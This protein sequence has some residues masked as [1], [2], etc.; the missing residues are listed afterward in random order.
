MCRWA[1][2]TTTCKLPITR[3]TNAR[4][5]VIIRIR[6]TAYRIR[7]TSITLLSIKYCSC[8]TLA[9][10]SINIKETLY[11]SAANTI[12]FFILI[13]SCTI[14]TTTLSIIPFIAIYAR[15]RILIALITIPISSW[16]AFYALIIWRKES[17]NA[18]TINTIKY[19]VW[20]AIIVLII[21]LTNII[22]FTESLFANTCISS[23]YLILSA[24]L[25]YLT[26]SIRKYS[27]RFWASTI[28]WFSIPQTIWIWTLLRW[29]IRPIW[30]FWSIRS[31]RSVWLIRD[32][33][34]YTRPNWIIISNTSTTTI[35]ISNTI[36][37]TLL[38][39]TIHVKESDST[40]ALAINQYLIII[41][42]DNTIT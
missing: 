40:F 10:F 4:I 31:A 34:C 42:F 24:I 28:I 33:T 17:I 19:W 25:M 6:I 22:Y 41:T 14:I 16:W 39:S 35:T 18:L 1:C 13:T 2:Y 36:F 30:S 21:S 3:N 7:I 11:T 38:A 8:W 5:S 12:P 37:R 9:T 23:P 20:L 32:R 15:T 29:T 27:S 26:T